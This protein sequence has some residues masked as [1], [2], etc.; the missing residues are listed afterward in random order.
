MQLAATIMSNPVEAGFTQSVEFHRGEA[1][2]PFQ[3][4]VT[5]LV[6]DRGM[7]KID[8]SVYLMMQTNQ[9][10]H[11]VDSLIR[12]AALYNQRHQC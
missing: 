12:S 1:Q 5:W 3:V 9:Q 4:R 7:I 10:R 11:H 2:N 6:A 8:S